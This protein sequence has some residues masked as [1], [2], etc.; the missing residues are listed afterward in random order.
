MCF[1]YYRISPAEAGAQQRKTID[2]SNKVRIPENCSVVAQTLHTL[3]K[4]KL[5]MN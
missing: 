2:D 3:I 4:L 1:F 5:D